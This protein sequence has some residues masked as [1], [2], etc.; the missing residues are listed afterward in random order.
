MSQYLIDTTINVYET[1]GRD[2]MVELS[3]A[4][5]ARVF[6]DQDD[7]QFAA[8]F[9]GRHHD[10]AVLGVLWWRRRLEEISPLIHVQVRN[11]Y[12][13]F[14]QRMGGP[15]LYTEHRARDRYGGHPALRGRHAPFTI[16]TRMAERWLHHMKL[17]LDDVGIEE[18]SLVRDAMWEFFVDVAHFLKNAPDD[19]PPAQ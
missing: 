8:N 5:Y 10:A 19:A 1:L 17:A 13:F 3:E 6:A 15:A 11:Q 9:R 4:F 12:E 18:G 16:N 2:K 7:P 14:I